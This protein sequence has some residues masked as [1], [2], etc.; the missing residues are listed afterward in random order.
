MG[1]ADNGHNTGVK[2]FTH[3]QH[4]GSQVVVQRYAGNTDQLG[5]IF[6][7]LLPDLLRPI[8]SHQEIED[9]DL[10]PVAL[11]GSGEVSKGERRERVLF[12]RMCRTDK[13]NAQRLTFLSYQLI[14]GIPDGT[15]SSG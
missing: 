14:P 7:Q 3:L 9:L 10:E 15:Y 1:T 2:C 4:L 12:Q 6:L 8:T 11:K 5:S 13:Q